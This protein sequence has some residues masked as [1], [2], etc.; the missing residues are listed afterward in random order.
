MRYF[1]NSHF[2][3]IMM[4]VP[5]VRREEQAPDALSLGHRCVGCASYSNGCTGVCYRQLVITPKRKEPKQCG[6]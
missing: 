2:E 6:L 4:Q 5:K 1:T 3:R